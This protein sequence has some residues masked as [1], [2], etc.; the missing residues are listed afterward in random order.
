MARFCVEML[1]S[2]DVTIWIVETVGSLLISSSRDLIEV[3][4]GILITFEIHSRSKGSYVDHPYQSISSFL[5]LWKISFVND[6]VTNPLPGVLLRYC[7]IPIS[8]RS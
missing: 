7:P 3:H 4:L 1:V 5:S 6:F 2:V 8:A